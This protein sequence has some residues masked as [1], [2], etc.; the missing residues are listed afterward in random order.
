MTLRHVRRGRT[1][2]RGKKEAQQVQQP[3]GQRL[4]KKIEKRKRRV[5]KMIGL[6]REGH[7]ISWATEFRGREQNMAAITCNR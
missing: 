1:E 6:Y 4:K 7:P 3:G 5:I 2:G